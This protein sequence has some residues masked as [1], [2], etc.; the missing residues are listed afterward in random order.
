M[1]EVKI[2]I[3]NLSVYFN[4]IQ[5]LNDVSL[6]IFENK[7]T[8]L[9]G[10]SGC[11]KTSLLRSLNRMNDM[12][13]GFRM[14]GEILIDDIDIY[15]KEI[16]VVN[17]RRLVGMVFQQSN[18]FPK[19]IYDNLIFAPKIL[20]IKDKTELEEIAERVCTQTSIWNEVK[21]RLDES[22]LNLSAGQ[23]QRLCIARAL[24][25]DPDILLMDEP[26]SSLDPVSTSKIEELLFD[27]KRN[28]TILIVTHNMQQAARISDY[29]AYLYLGQ[30][31]EYDKTTK[32][33]TNPANKQTEDFLTGRFG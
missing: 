13:Y 33:F 31:V 23:Q 7:V 5:A 8:C 19:S 14:N 21:D 6:E 12:I 9:I 1:K 26:S 10:P 17:L 30:L 22:A 29:T 24:T 2:K 25:V 28:Y 3:K 11:G 4:Y 16:D 20:G 18:L 15:N 32:I 27:L